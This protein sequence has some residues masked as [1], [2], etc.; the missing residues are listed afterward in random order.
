MVPRHIVRPQAGG[1]Q[2]QLAADD[3]NRTPAKA[4]FG[5]PYY[6]PNRLIANWQRSVPAD[7]Y[8]VNNGRPIRHMEE[9]K[10]A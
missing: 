1:E 3:I 5:H 8:P 4:P 2:C 9:E 7:F 6:S 10:K